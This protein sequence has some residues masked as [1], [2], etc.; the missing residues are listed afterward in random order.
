MAVRDPFELRRGHLHSQCAK[1]N[2]VDI[3]VEKGGSESGPSSDGESFGTQSIGQDLQR[4][5]PVTN[6]GETDSVESIEL[7][8]SII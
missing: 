7:R 5:K 1:G 3:D 8:Q 4:I 2:R 6:R